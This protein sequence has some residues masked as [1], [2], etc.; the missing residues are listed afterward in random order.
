MSKRENNTKHKTYQNRNSL[1]I[2]SSQRRLSSNINNNK[3]NKTVPSQQQQQQPKPPLAQKKISSD[4]LTTPTQPKLPII[5]PPTKPAP[6]PI[7][8]TTTT[9]SSSTTST[10]SKTFLLRPSD[11][12]VYYIC[13]PEC[14]STIPNIEKYSITPT[15]NEIHLHITC[16]KCNINSQ[17]YPLQQLLPS[18]EQFLSNMSTLSFISTCSI[19]PTSKNNYYCIKCNKSLCY[20]CSR[21]IHASHPILTLEEYF[22]EIDKQ[23]P[24]H[25][26]TE[27]DNYVNKF[28]AQNEEYK[29][30]IVSKINKEIVLLSQIK[31]QVEESLINNTNIN[32]KLCSLL[33]TLYTNYLQYNNYIHLI[34]NFDRI[35][36]L[37]TNTFTINDN[38]PIYTSSTQLITYFNHNHIIHPYHIHKKRIHSFNG[39]LSVINSIIQ[40]SFYDNALITGS[41]DKTIKIWETYNTYACIA[42]LHGHTRAVNVLC[43]LKNKLLASGSS[44]C[45]III[46]DVFTR[47][48]VTYID[49]HSSFI[50]GLIQLSD[51]RVVSGSDDKTIRIWKDDFTP[52]SCIA[53]T[54]N[55]FSCIEIRT[56]D[57]MQRKRIAVGLADNDIYLCYINHRY[58][59]VV[60]KEKLSGHTGCVRTLLQLKSGHLVSGS[61]DNTIKIWDVIKKECICTLKDHY[62]FV[63]ALLELRDGR[64]VSAAFD[65]SVRF[66]NVDNYQSLITIKEDSSNNAIVELKDGRIAIG[67]SSNVVS[68]WY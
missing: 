8:I 52:L 64:L 41:S 32:M 65:D 67:K 12:N 45:Y 66:W 9:P 13:C 27:F 60:Q 26:T 61:N 3:N 15:T 48:S 59:D 33:K 17:P 21:E 42:T 54:S 23:L 55:V 22:R 34:S 5:Q 25:N 68:L 63:N 11:K 49:A 58:F 46:W 2:I 10:T 18:S 20:S 47:T 19:H 35:C 30:N 14:K 31:K 51:D 16:S 57:N 38:T 29:V 40:L 56:D 50:F 24:F 37:N 36:Q 7:N 44:D 28:T 1:P 39:H 4:T 43:E 53:F 6:N 62:L